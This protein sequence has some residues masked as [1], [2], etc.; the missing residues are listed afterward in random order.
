MVSGGLPDRGTIHARQ[1]RADNKPRTTHAR[2][3]TLD[4]PQMDEAASAPPTARRGDLSRFSAD[5][6][7][8]TP[9]G[10][11]AET[12]ARHRSVR[13]RA[14]GSPTRAATAKRLWLSQ[15]S[16]SPRCSARPGASRRRSALPSWDSPYRR[17]SRRGSVHASQS[18]QAQD[19]APRSNV[20]RATM[21]PCQ[22]RDASP[23][24]AQCRP[25]HRSHWL[26]TLAPG[27]Q[28][29]PSTVIPQRPVAV[30]MPDDTRQP[31][32]TRLKTS[33]TLKA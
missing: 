2:Q 20:L 31:L 26:Q 6:H 14:I 12:N 8:V 7:H 11:H 22:R 25:R 3:P 4:P 1:G 18:P 5:L 29:E 21:T 19:S 16:N 10:G 13:L 28:E 27:R 32:K 15:A 17:R 30:G 24:A 9:H 33:F 23:D